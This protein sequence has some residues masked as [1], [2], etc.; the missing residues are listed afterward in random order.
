M[1]GD[2]PVFHVQG[3]SKDLQGGN[4]VFKGFFEQTARK[5]FHQRMEALDEGAVWRQI[6]WIQI[7]MALIKK[8]RE[9]SWTKQSVWLIFWKVASEQGIYGSSEL[10]DHGTVIGKCYL[11]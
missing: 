2:I 7:S 5:L 6:E 11:R 9:K 3:D 8:Q 10:Q 1:Q 4:L